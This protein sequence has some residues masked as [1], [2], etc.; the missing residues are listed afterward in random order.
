[1]ADSNVLIVEDEEL[2]RNILRELV[3]K[4]GYSAFTADSAEAAIE[5]FTA[6]DISATLTDI[7]MAGRDGLDLLDQIKSVDSEAVVIIMTAY[8]SVDTAVAAL[9]K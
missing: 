1:M 8:S 2:M 7:K 6:N 9:R 4:A 3:S 5:I